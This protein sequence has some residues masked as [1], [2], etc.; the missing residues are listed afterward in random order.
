MSLNN[1][2]SEGHVPTTEISHDKNLNSDDSK[3]EKD[4][5]PYEK[6]DY[7]VA[8]AERGTVSPNGAV[9]GSDSGRSKWSRFY[10]RYRIFFHIF[11]WLVFTGYD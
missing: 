2:V 3:V 11:I 7:D 5:I 8:S 9:T 4:A 10:R 6:T 1:T